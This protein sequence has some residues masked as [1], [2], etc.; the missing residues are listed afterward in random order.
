MFADFCLMISIRLAAS[1]PGLPSEERERM[2][3]SPPIRLQIAEGTIIWLILQ[4]RGDNFQF[5]FVWV[6]IMCC[7]KLQHLLS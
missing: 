7:V 4:L 5:C 1:Y 2:H 3:N 6:A